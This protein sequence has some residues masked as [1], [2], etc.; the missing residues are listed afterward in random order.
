MALVIF[1]SFCKPLTSQAQIVLYDSCHQATPFCGNNIYN[2]NVGG[3]SWAVALNECCPGDIPPQCC[4]SYSCFSAAF[5]QIKNPR[6]F[7]FKVENPG[8]II[9]SLLLT[10]Y[11]AGVGEHICW[12]PFDNPITPCVAG[13]T[14]EKIAACCCV[15]SN[16]IN[17]LVVPQAE[18]GKYYLF[19]LSTIFYQGTPPNLQP[20]QL[21]FFQSNLGQPGAGSTTCDLVTNCT[22]LQLTANPSACNAVTNTYTLSGKVFFVNP[23][24]TGQLVIWDNVTGNSLSFNAPFTS[25]LNYNFAALPCDNLLHTLTA[26]FWDATGCELTTQFQAPVLCPDATLSGGG[27]ICNDGAA[28]A[29]ISISFTPN[30]QLPYTFSWKIDGMAQPAIVD[31]SGQLPYVFQTSQPGTYT[32]NS[33]SNAQCAGLLSGQALVN[34][35]PLPS[36]NLG[37]DLFACAGTPVVLDAGP[38]F[39]SY[40]WSNE[41]T[42]QS[43]TVAQA[44]NYTVT[45]MD[46]NGCQASD[47]I[48]VQYMP[49]IPPLFIKHE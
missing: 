26:S 29:Q 32:M 21:T 37:N 46:T 19:A 30:A 33:S 4:A 20:V 24:Q 1:L 28:Q 3:I 14:E 44:G 23:P 41:M 39:S 27:S 35:L 8:T 6:W 9:I 47:T 31:Y 15:E 40:Y 12:G 36:I 18:A 2:Y 11:V 38:G 22:M 42:T 48:N 45:V 5:T 7:F 49:A 17:N 25:P 43:I 34:L 10:P 16:C 13:L